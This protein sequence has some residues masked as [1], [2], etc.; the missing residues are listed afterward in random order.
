[1][2]EKL[3][4]NQENVFKFDPEMNCVYVPRLICE[5]YEIS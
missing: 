3:K 1:M 5:N 2:K 4:T